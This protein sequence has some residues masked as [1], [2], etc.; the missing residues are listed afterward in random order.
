MMEANG[1][2][3]GHMNY[4]DAPTFSSEWSWEREER[5]R[6]QICQDDLYKF[7]SDEIMV[8]DLIGAEP[9]GHIN[10]DD[11]SDPE[12]AAKPVSQE[13]GAIDTPARR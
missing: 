10:K 6:K 7:V 8:S 12:H 13:D 4:N 5:E 11:P 1:H 9:I 2:T 3:M